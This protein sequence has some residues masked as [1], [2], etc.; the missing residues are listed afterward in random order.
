MTLASLLVPGAL[1]L[2]SAL[3]LLALRR[4]EGAWSWER[5]L[6]RAALLA[7]LVLGV[8]DLGL[9][10]PESARPR[11]LVLDRSRSMRAAAR[12]VDRV[13]AG[14]LADLR[15]DER[16]GIVSFGA[17][18]RIVTPPIPVA[19]VRAQLAE[20]LASAPPDWGSDLAGALRLAASLLPARA[21]ELL[22]ISD[23][24]DP[25]ARA[26]ASAAIARGAPIH[27]YGPATPPPAGAR[28]ARLE[29]PPRA[30]PGQRVPLRAVVA[31]RRPTRF[32]LHLERRVGRAWS[33]LAR[34]EGQVE[35]DGEAVLRFEVR[36]PRGRR[37]AQLVLR[38]RVATAGPDE[39]PEDDALEARVAVGDTPR[40][41]VIGRPLPRLAGRTLQVESVRPAEL[42]T[43]L[44]GGLPELIV[45]SDVSASSLRDQVGALDA[46]L[47]AGVGLVVAGVRG[48][49]PGG[50]AGSSLE[51]L[52]PVTCGPSQER[53]RSLAV[54]VA[55]DA[56][57]SMA[58][59]VG[60]GRYY[61]AVQRGVP[62]ERLRP[63]DSVAV[64][65]F[66]DQ[67]RVH[68]PFAPVS[69]TLREGLTSV[70]PEGGTD[71]GL[72]LA[73]SL[74]LLAQQESD[75]RLL[76]L[77]TDSEEGA[78]RRHAARLG[79]A[80]RGLAPSTR[81]ALIH[82]GEGSLES[83][84]VLASL[85]AGPEVRVLRAAG[86][87]EELRQLLEGELVRGQTEVQQ[88]P[89]ALR[90]LPPAQAL[91]LLPPSRSAAY[92]AVRA[93]RSDD[94]RQRGVQV[95]GTLADPDAPAD[96]PPPWGV[97]GRRGLG[98]VLCLPLPVEECLPLIRAAAGRLARSRGAELSLEAGRAGGGLELV[99]QSEAALPGNL[100]AR[101]LEPSGA[102]LIPL[103]PEG[104]R[105][106]RGRVAAVGPDPLQVV[107]L[108]AA[109]GAGEGR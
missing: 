23:G 84:E 22:L 32:V 3:A 16:V 26:A 39:G 109:A 2:L 50:Y 31:A 54:V 90:V 52:L 20:L 94:A 28:V 66:A 104:T 46:A 80:A 55:L 34:Q 99:V 6:L 19:R 67:P 53:Q 5:W 97:L 95:L 68:Q 4:R 83:L 105:R 15:G 37:A 77:A 49:G 9:P 70:D 85:I 14:A 27:V 86:A 71:V 81:V 21:G 91:G 101:L 92:V 33:E 43:S 12:E 13:V 38:A 108:G 35:S 63:E 36:A 61:Q 62:W 107:L 82:L 64:V 65:L 48:F 98:Q 29:A 1:A 106:A 69:Q 56:S 25:A 41:L 18:A 103:I 102:R 72:A 79:E 74:E 60:N 75:E 11:G 45:L 73:R 30:A 76:I 51:D 24:H 57:G 8:A 88:G 42:A 93:R 87:G 96:E 40:A 44:R 10:D 47:R 59:P 7:T 17:E 58:R 100:E 89:F 78:P